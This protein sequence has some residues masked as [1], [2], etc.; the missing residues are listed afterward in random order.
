MPRS[1]LEFM[2]C[3]DV[4]DNPQ[5]DCVAGYYVINILELSKIEFRLLKFNIT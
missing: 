1:I 2:M 3:F 4:K 5:V